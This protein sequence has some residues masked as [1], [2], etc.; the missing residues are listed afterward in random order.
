MISCLSISVGNCFANL[1]LLV[2]KIAEASGSCSAWASISDATWSNSADLSAIINQ[3]DTYGL[4]EA[5]EE[6]NNQVREDRD[7]EH[8]VGR[9][10]LEDE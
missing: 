9:A 3:F 8:M 7:W 5:V 1:W 4:L 10:V 6:V 2:I